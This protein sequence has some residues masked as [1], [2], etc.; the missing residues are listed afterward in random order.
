[1]TAI[2]GMRGRN[3]VARALLLLALA[4][5]GLP[6]AARAHTTDAITGSVKTGVVPNCGESP[7]CQAFIAAG[8]RSELPVK[9]GIEISIVRLANGLAGGHR[10]RIT[11]TATSAPVQNVVFVQFIAECVAT[12]VTLRQEFASEGILTIPARATWVVV[13]AARPVDLRW[14]MQGVGH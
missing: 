14:S 8:C 6:G 12:G 2:G 13:S 7:T 11:F 5:A 1:M 9:D 3:R 10:A 4:T